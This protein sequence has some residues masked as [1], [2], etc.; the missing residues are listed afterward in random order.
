MRSPGTP[1]APDGGGATP[2]QGG[3]QV[4]SVR[5]PTTL[6][7]HE[8]AGGLEPIVGQG[9]ATQGEDA[10]PASSSGAMSKD[11]LQDEE[12]DPDDI[13]E[14]LLDIFEE[15][16]G[17]GDLRDASRTLD[18]LEAAV[19]VNDP[20]YLRAFAVHCWE[21]EGASRARWC[22]ENAVRAV[23]DDPELRYAYA[24]CLAELGEFDAMVEQYLIVRSLDLAYEHRT[25]SSRLLSTIHSHAERVL[26]RLPR[27]IQQRLENVPV[28][29]E[30]RP[31]RHHV[32]AGL[33]P[34]LLGLF[35]G[36]D[37]LG[38]PDAIPVPTRVVVFYANLVA[39]FGDD[40]ETLLD[41]LEVTILHEIGHFFGLDE[42]DVAALG[43]E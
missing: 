23:P 41:E 14:Y 28:V 20:R 4:P 1:R 11:G 32:E 3:E 22:F 40:E 2:A 16:L 27:D 7:I 21:A 12:P 8:L 31:A 17:V 39:C 26:S 13:V 30:P 19:G 33:D 15:Q 18:E 38:E 24:H 9:G 10:T 43:L 5:L 29:L 25:A 36:R 35:E 6:D 42:D 37:L 34:R